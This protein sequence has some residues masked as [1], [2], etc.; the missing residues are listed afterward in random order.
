MIYPLT[1][2][3]TPLW[4]SFSGALGLGL[5]SVIKMSLL[6]SKKTIL[7]HNTGLPTLAASGVWALGE[8]YRRTVFGII[9]VIAYVAFAFVVGYS[10]DLLFAATW[11]TLPVVL[12][13]SPAKQYSV[14]SRA[15][16]A[17]IMAHIVG[18]FIALVTGAVVQ[19]HTLAGVVVVER[20]VAALGIIAVAYALDGVTSVIRTAYC[21][22]RE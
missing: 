14:V 5:W 12:L 22:S 13:L 4:S 3:F 8:A 2:W 9:P 18:T 11:L 16:A 15:W 6:A 10:P 17:S 1:V 19:W 20:C 21:A 7:F